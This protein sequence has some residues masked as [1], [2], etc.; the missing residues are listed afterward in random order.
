M[1]DRE[2]PLK[3][4]THESDVGTIGDA[5][6]RSY[7]IEEALSFEIEIVGFRHDA[8]VRVFEDISFTPRRS[9]HL[10]R[11]LTKTD[12]PD[13]DLG[14]FAASF[15]FALGDRVVVYTGDVA[16]R[17]DLSLFADAPIDAMICEAAH[18]GADELL[19]ALEESRP[20][21]LLLVHW[22]LEDRRE[23]LGRLL[24]ENVAA[25]EFAADGQTI[26]L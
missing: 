14:Y 12:S 20:S 6:R 24:G 5:L 22:S 7:M 3:I 10:N 18:V 1:A 23:L 2:K 15:R 4:F 21:R 25:V 13:E 9:S 11:Y 8:P 17:E 19:S 26:L 16:S